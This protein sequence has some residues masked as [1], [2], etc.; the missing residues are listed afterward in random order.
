MATQR[1]KWDGLEPE[2]ALW[3]GILHQAVRDATQTTEER[4]RLEA[5]QF[6]E[7]CAPTVADKL[8]ESLISASNVHQKYTE[9]GAD[10]WLVNS[11]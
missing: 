2:Y 11:T 3:G 9:K 6:L 4:M 10:L 8:R 5:W 7:V 1:N